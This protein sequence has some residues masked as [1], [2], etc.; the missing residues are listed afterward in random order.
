MC[1]VLS[2]GEA[3][4]HTEF[5]SVLPEAISYKRFTDSEIYAIFYV[6]TPQCVIPVN[7]FPQ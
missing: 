7:R 4:R 1:T 3:S 5:R 2:V 6:R